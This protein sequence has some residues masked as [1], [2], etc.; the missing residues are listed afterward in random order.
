LFTAR[1]GH[2]PL[3]EFFN[4]FDLW[5]SLSGINEDRVLLDLMKDAVDPQ[6]VQAIGI[7]EWL[8]TYADFKLVAREIDHVQQDLRYGS[9]FAGGCYQGQQQPLQAPRT[10]AYKDSLNRH[11]IRVDDSL[12][13]PTFRSLWRIICL[14]IC[15]FTQGLVLHFWGKASPWKL[16]EDARIDLGLVI[17]VARW[18]TLCAIA[19]AARAVVEASRAKG[20]IV[21][22][23]DEVIF[24][25][26]EGLEDVV[27][28]GVTTSSL[29]ETF[30]LHPGQIRY[31]R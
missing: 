23:K 14:L 20:S 26:V 22:L 11:V 19:H 3:D 24:R 1:Q 25:V 13:P 27:E 28:E 5:V 30:S 31:N 29:E 7:R 4:V 6:I 2:L 15:R 8:A 18:A 9:M 21:H 17:S 10:T 12:T 16:V